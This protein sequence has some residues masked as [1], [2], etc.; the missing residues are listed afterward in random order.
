MCGPGR[1]IQPASRT[2][3]MERPQKGKNR[4]QLLCGWRKVGGEW[5]EPFAQ[6]T[7]GM[8]IQPIPV[9]EEIRTRLDGSLDHVGRADSQNSAT[10]AIL[11]A[12]SERPLVLPSQPS[13]SQQL[14]SC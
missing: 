10:A 1:I 3:S 5:S 9:T 11:A 12:H 7:Q 8:P 13:K 6:I 2:D 14:A 4:T